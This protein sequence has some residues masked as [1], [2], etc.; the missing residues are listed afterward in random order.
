MRCLAIAVL[1]AACHDLPD[2]GICGNGII[3][4]E[5]GEACDGDLAGADS[6]T[7]TCEL[8]CQTSAVGPAYVVVGVDPTTM[9]ELYCPDLAM[10]CGL[11]NIC[12]AASGSFGTIGAA[13]PFDVKLANVGDFDGD[14]IDDLV[15][16]SAT[17]IV[18]RFGTSA[19][20][21][22]VD[23]FEQAAPSSESPLAI[24]DRNP[25]TVAVDLSDLTI[26]VPT[27]GLA[28]LT[29]DTESFNPDLDVTFDVDADT[30][31]HFVVADPD[32]QLGDV[33]M[34]VTKLGTI[35]VKRIA[36]PP[37]FPTDVALAAC[38]GA[39]SRLIDVV[40]AKDR[41][42]FVIIVKPNAATW[43]ACTYTP[44]GTTFAA[45]VVTTFATAPPDTVV[46]ADIEGDACPELVLARRLPPPSTQTVIGFVGTT[47]ACVLANTVTALQQAT[48]PAAN[49]LLDAGSIVPSA[50]G[51]ER[52]E[53]VMTSGVY[54]VSPTLTLE[55]VARPTSDLRPWVAA[56]VVDLNGDGQLDVVAG[57]K[58]QDDVDVVRGGAT[59]N[60]YRT[61]T[62]A[63]VTAT[64]AGDFD[65]DFLGDVA[66]VEAGI[67]DRV[68]ILYGASDGL[69]GPARENSRFQGK[70][71]IA[72]LG[73]FTWGQTA[74]GSDGVDDLVV[75]LTDTMVGTS[76]GGVL[77]GDA[78]RLLTMPRFPPT[79]TPAIGA[80]A[81]GKL[82][83][84]KLLAA[85]IRPGAPGTSELLIHDVATA[86]WTGP[87]TVAAFEA[88]TFTPP[89]ILRTAGAPVIATFSRGTAT[90]AT[91]GAF[92]IDGKACTK[93]VDG[94]GFLLHA[95]DVAGD[96]EIDE[97]VFTSI[98][99][100]ARNPRQAHI[101]EVAVTAG[102]CAIGGELLASALVGCADVVRVG[103]QTVALCE[104]APRQF[105][106]FR[107]TDEGTR[108]PV[109]FAEVDGIGLQLVVG[110]FD[111]DAVA[112]L[113]VGVARG[114]E[115]SIQ[116]LRQCPA[117]D[118]RGCR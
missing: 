85:A 79:Q 33:V 14:R 18:V 58:E 113:G 74:R 80:I 117:H 1:L 96:D 10:G 9:D 7:A 40:I 50:S 42:S 27:D 61:D 81:V 41:R 55:L 43:L 34:A 94:R 63:P 75:T 20:T 107:I 108:E 66:L 97:L 3:E 37:T 59:P 15:G 47:G 29:S 109:A 70:L 46:A 16:T 95:A 48:L 115:I 2:L 19:G 87:L 44:S 84:A 5:L 116:F 102:Q 68:S 4:A 26:G 103:A 118:T 104:S 100:G 38:G 114:A 92:A 12:R 64:V 31:V 101:F 28:V 35:G 69:V 17:Q 112:D 91:F 93:T 39:N 51:P 77:I 82:D 21:P 62:A 99:L 78:P 52:D 8:T 73:S 65:G 57:R 36:I 86:E 90:T 76:S 106:V 110:D 105:G 67:G 30:F 45:P 56:S 32:T 6:C 60:V 72:R 98:T 24:F 71:S 111:G 89:Q 23:G 22:F 25:D 11:D 54:R 88:D 83:G 53:V 13:Q 49:D